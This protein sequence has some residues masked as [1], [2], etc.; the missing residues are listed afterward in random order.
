MFVDLAL[1][2]SSTRP[3]T[4][5]LMSLSPMP[6]RVWPKLRYYPA[7]KL[8]VLTLNWGVVRK[9]YEYLYR[10]TFDVYTNN[11]PL[12]YILKM[13]KL[14]VASHWWVAR[15]ANYNIWLHYRLRK[16][17][18]DTGALSRVSWPRCMTDTMGM[19]QCISATVV[20]AVQE[21]TLKGLVSPIGAC[22]CDL[23]ILDPV[24][25]SWQVVC[26]TTKD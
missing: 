19:Y 2:P 21:A 9:F 16:T 11:N 20:W 10:S 22:S 4:M 1:G 24:E 14:D 5:G 3:L 25:D 17:N 7:H 8:E 6:A 23:H 15:L 18:V 26:M 13:A 12:P